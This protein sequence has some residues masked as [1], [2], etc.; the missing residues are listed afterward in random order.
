[1]SFTSYHKLID[2]YFSEF[3]LNKRTND[4]SFAKR[5]FNEDLKKYENRLKQINFT[6]KNNVLDYGCGFGQWSLALSNLNNKVHSC[7]ISKNRCNFLKF[8]K[9]HKSISNI[10]I[11]HCNPLKLPYPKNKFD[12]LFC[13]GVLFCGNWKKLIIE[14][15]RVLKPNGKLY[16]NANDIGWYIYLWETEKNK[17]FDFIPR[18]TVAQAFNNT[19]KFNKDNNF[20]PKSGEQIIIKKNDLVDYLNQSSFT[21]IET[22]KEGTINK[23]KKIKQ[24]PFFKGSYKGMDCVY[25]II[26]K[27][28]I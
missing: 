20:T 22:G 24:Q 8:I 5:V 11:K 9:K 6:K 27:K 10:E 28:R 13:Y 15:K 1:M 16:L 7:D 14:F 25:E 2:K 12:A 4:F 21:N 19:I 17:S 3:H 23:N 26:A 18:K